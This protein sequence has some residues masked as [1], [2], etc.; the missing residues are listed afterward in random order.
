MCNAKLIM[1]SL[2]YAGLT[3]FPTSAIALLVPRPPIL[4]ASL[5]RSSRVLL[6]NALWRRFTKDNFPSFVWI[7]G[8]HCDQFI[9]SITAGLVSFATLLSAVALVDDTIRSA[10]ELHPHWLV[11]AFRMKELVLQCPFLVEFLG[12]VRPWLQR[13]NPD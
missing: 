2:I 8:E 9:R 1:T 10:M 13:A 11:G 5:L 7:V 12:V 4:M 3:M 6:A